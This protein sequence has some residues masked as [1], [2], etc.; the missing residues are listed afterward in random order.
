MEESDNGGGKRTPGAPKALRGLHKH[1]NGSF[2]RPGPLL[3]YLE[4]SY[5]EYR[6]P[7]IAIHKKTMTQHTARKELYLASLA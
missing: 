4:N 5:V 2:S 7:H 3:T 6:Y 1:C